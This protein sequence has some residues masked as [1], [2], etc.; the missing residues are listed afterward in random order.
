MVA[1]GNAPDGVAELR[2]N[3]FGGIRLDDVRRFEHHTFT[4]EELDDLDGARGHPASEILHRDHVGDD[5]LAGGLGRFLA[6]SLALLTFPLARAPHRS[7]GGHALHGALIVSGDRLDRQPALTALGLATQARNRLGRSGLALSRVLLIEVRT[8]IQVEAAW[9]G[10]L[11]RRAAESRGRP[12]RAAYAPK[13]RTARRAGARGAVPGVAAAQRGRIAH[14]VA[15][16]GRSSAD[17]A[18]GLSVAK[19]FPRRS[20]DAGV[21]PSSP[22]AEG[23]ATGEPFRPIGGRC[24]GAPRG[25]RGPARR[26]WFGQAPW[27]RGALGGLGPAARREGPW[28]AATASAARGR[29]ARRRGHG[30]GWLGSDNLVG[31]LVRDGFRG[32]RFGHRA[33]RRFS[34]RCSC[35]L[36]AASMT[37]WRAPPLLLG[38]AA[39][40]GGRGGGGRRGGR[41]PAH[42]EGRPTISRTWRRGVGLNPPTL[43]PPPRSWCGR[44]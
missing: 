12:A 33:F 28:G 18:G 7:K 32:W 1:F 10:R 42:V 40:G 43:G 29:R 23:D 37:L 20:G 6:A 11:P 13:S 34:A 27:G 25:D 17:P 2:R 4:S 15:G 30:G 24:S 26:S 38:E 3:Q 14:R 36:R 8:A 19:A 21:G 41:G 9:T 5:D 16:A 35:W 39:R 22:L 31:R 44:G